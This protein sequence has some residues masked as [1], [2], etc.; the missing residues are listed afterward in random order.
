MAK[1]I[2]TAAISAAVF[3]GV[4]TGAFVVASAATGSSTPSDTVLGVYKGGVPLRPTSGNEVAVFGPKVSASSGGMNSDG[5]ATARLS[6]SSDGLCVEFVS[7]VEKG[8]SCNS[9]ADIQTGVAY[10]AF[11]GPDQIVHV[12]GIVPDDAS[13]VEIAGKHVDVKDNLWMFSAP[14]GTDLTFTVYSADKAHH[15]TLGE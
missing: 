10:G 1:P 15:V 3:A 12:V 6:T 8:R 4:T 9:L 13:F 11:T 2:R 7:D 5:A 14:M